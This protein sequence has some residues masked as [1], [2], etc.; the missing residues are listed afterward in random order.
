MILQKII[1]I[2][3]FII[4]LLLGGF[5][6]YNKCEV[7]LFMWKDLN[8]SKASIMCLQEGKYIQAE[9]NLKEYFMLAY[10]YDRHNGRI[11]FINIDTNKQYLLLC[12]THFQAGQIANKMAI[13]LLNTPSI[14]V[15]NKYNFQ[16]LKG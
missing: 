3:D 9:N 16:E 6:I 1:L 12:D 10:G 14:Q 2:I 11:V 15:L 4:P 8:I 7:Y 5:F 13:E